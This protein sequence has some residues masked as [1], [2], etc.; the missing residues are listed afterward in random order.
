MAKDLVYLSRQMYKIAKAVEEDV[1]DFVKMV[2][3]DTHEQ[4]VERTPV[5]V[6]TARSNW[7]ARIGV[8]WRYVYRAFAPGS[9]LGRGERGNLSG[10]VRQ[11]RA[12]ISRRKPEQTI[13]ITNNLPYITRLN[14]GYSRQSPAGFVQSGILVGISAARQKFRFKNVRRIF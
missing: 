5:D 14:S 12:V 8:P 7:I 11:A 13:Y 3:A 2:A 1:N 6:G 10:A 4:I 9:H